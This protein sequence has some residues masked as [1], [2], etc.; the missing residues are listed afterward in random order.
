MRANYLTDR[1]APAVA[2]MLDKNST[3]EALNLRTNDFSARSA[4]AQCCG[5]RGVANDVCSREHPCAC[6]TWTC[7]HSEH[8]R[9]GAYAGRARVFNLLSA[10]AL[11]T[12][13][14]L[15]E[16][17]QPSCHMPTHI[18][19]AHLHAFPSRRAPRSRQARPP[20]HL[21]R[22]RIASKSAGVGLSVSVPLRMEWGRRGPLI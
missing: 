4:C 17:L 18:C 15:R 21:R 5:Q 14:G 19:G 2:A 12:I 6:S 8:W 13:A 3:L 22:P 1:S 7:I 11:P 9:R 10:A 16:P 20:T